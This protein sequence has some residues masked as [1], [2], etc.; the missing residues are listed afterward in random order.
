MNHCDV[1]HTVHRQGDDPC[2]KKRQEAHVQ[3]F[4]ENDACYYPF[5]KH[6]HCA[7]AQHKLLQM[8]DIFSLY[9]VAELPVAPTNSSTPFPPPLIVDSFPHRTRHTQRLMGIESWRTI[10][11][12]MGNF[13]FIL[14]AVAE[15]RTASFKAQ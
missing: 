8:S 10:Y 9:V 15:L 6:A 7:F 3:D 11:M 14:P 13:I 12:Q 4:M 1:T 5:W 2:D